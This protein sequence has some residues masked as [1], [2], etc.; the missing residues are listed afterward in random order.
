MGMTKVGNNVQATLLHRNM[1]E[2]IHRMRRQ[3]VS[4]TFL[5]IPL[6]RMI[7]KPMVRPTLQCDVLKLMG[8]FC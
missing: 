4:K 3:P 7:H 1:Y 2:V 8:A 5:R 6:C